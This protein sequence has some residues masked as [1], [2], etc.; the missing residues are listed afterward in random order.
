MAQHE[1]FIELVATVPGGERNSALGTHSFAAGFRAKVDALDDGSF[2]FADESDFDFNSSAANE[3]AARATG[4]VRFVTAIDGGGNP[5]AGVALGPGDTA[6]SVLSDA[7]TKENIAAVAGGEILERLT[8]IPIESWNYKHQDPSVRHIGPMAQDFYAAFG[9]GRDNGRISTL[10][11]DGI[12][13]AAIQGLHELVQE[14]DS[15]IAELKARLSALESLL[16]KLAP[17]QHGGVE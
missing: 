4:G 7:S 2:L 15:E 8:S 13:L 14:Q 16:T 3:F 5:V 11:A 10:D 6:W 17:Q 9:V 12:A 1:L